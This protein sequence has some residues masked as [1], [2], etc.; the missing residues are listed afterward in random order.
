MQQLFPLELLPFGKPL[1]QAK[2]EQR[3]LARGRSALQVRTLLREGKTPRKIVDTLGLSS[4]Q[5]YHV[6]STLRGWGETNLPY[7]REYVIRNREL[8][9]ALRDETKGDEKVQKL[10]RQVTRD[11]YL[12][13]TRGDKPL[14]MSVSNVAS[15]LQIKARNAHLLVEALQ[16]ATPRVPYGE[17]VHEVKSGPQKGKHHYFFLLTRHRER[18]RTALLA[19]ETLRP[20][21][22]PP[23]ELLCGY[24][25]VALPTTNS[26]VH[27]GRFRSPKHIFA[28]V[29]LQYWR[30]Q[31][32]V[33][34]PDFLGKDCP[35][36]IFS[37]G[38]RRHKVYYP[39]EQEAVLRTF[40]A[41]KAREL[42]TA[43]SATPSRH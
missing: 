25:N 14:F 17:L 24:W 26:L 20:F 6:R 22:Q 41:R 40:V 39:V 18:A 2:R 5:L 43:S 19:D 37:Y 12:S 11:F 38:R 35:V 27:S 16:T 8:E 36:P 7:T 34:L 30:P 42:A 28:E 21:L 33:S 15:E 3:S 1:P 32:N 9:A 4:Q 29:G 23:L 13:R 31:S 10:L